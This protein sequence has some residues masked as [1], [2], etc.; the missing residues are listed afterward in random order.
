MSAKSDLLAAAQALRERGMSTFTLIDVISEAKEQGSTYPDHTLRTMV[1]HHLRIDQRPVAGGVGFVQVSHGVYQLSSSDA[2]AIPRVAPAASTAEARALNPKSDEKTDSHEQGWFWE[3]NVQAAVVRHIASRGWHIRRVADTKSRENGV[4]IEA[5][6]DGVSLLIEVKGYPSDRYQ[7]GP[8]EGQKKNFGVGAQARTY[9]G[10]A[11]LAGT[12]LRSDSP[13]ARVVL[14]FP[15]V[16]TFATLARRSIL[17]L[18]KSNIEV[19]L[20]NEQGAVTE[21]SAHE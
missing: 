3:G 12:L 5:D 19:W 10:N 20:V 2:P 7:S 13:D 14:A 6:L 18:T 1:S 21:V 15:A 17:P 4:D 11:L 8:N 16:E 9:F